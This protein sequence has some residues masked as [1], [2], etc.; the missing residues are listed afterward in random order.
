MELLHRE[1][2]LELLKKPASPAVSIYLPTHRT[3]DTGA[4]AIAFRHLLAEAEQRLTE[5]GVRA[6]VARK[7]LAPAHELLSEALFWQYQ[8]EGLVCLVTPS[9]FG[10]YNLPFTV[11]ATVVVADEYYI[12]PLLPLLADDGIYYLL[13]LSLNNAALFRVRW[14]AGREIILSEESRSLAGANQ[15]DDSE[16]PLQYHTTGSGPAVFHGQADPEDFNKVHITHFLQKLSRELEKVLAAQRAPLVVAGVENIRAMFRAECAYANILPEGIE[17]NPDRM[18]PEHLRNEA[19]QIVSRHFERRR[20]QVLTQYL[21]EA[22]PERSVNGLEPVLFAAAD[23]RVT[24]LFLKEGLEAW[25]SI[26]LGERQIETTPAS[27]AGS[28]DL[29]EYAVRQTLMTGGD[30]YILKTEEQP[31]AAEI[32][33]LLRY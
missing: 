25:G 33:A 28:V 5:T 6:P 15:H 23:G 29:V 3:G 19:W 27:A 2:L 10:Y 31:E 32:A 11:P 8:E 16:K 14:L 21:E 26:D 22:R 18:T 1:D 7:M 4:D 17:G 30:I 12:R 24:A 9:S 13:S 20:R